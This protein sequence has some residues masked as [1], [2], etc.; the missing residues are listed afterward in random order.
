MELATALAVRGTLHTRGNWS[1][2][3]DRAASA[4]WLGILWVGVLAGFGVDFPRFLGENPPASPVIFVH[5]AVFTVWMLLLTAQVLL[6][7]GDR[8]GWHRTL[9]WFTAG[10]AL[11]VAVMGPWATVA[12]QLTNLHLPLAEPQFISINLA[13]L[14]GFLIL[15]A[16]GIVLRGNPAA[17]RRL[18]ILSTLSLA[19]DPGFSRFSEWLI[20]AEPASVL[21]WFF[22]SYYGNVLLV[23]LMLGWDW[24]RGRLMRSS[25]IAASALL[26]AEFAATL[27]YF[28]EPWK[29]LTAGW[30]Q[31]WAKFYA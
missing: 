27:L 6:V 11:L 1:A 31:M 2:R 18:M 24:W 28:W 15:L 9:G 16:W 19:G 26:A 10:W 12:F 5:A 7:L 17:H 23:V 8:V 20:P 30:V 25:V 29:A 22:W 14:G 4:V 3:D 13:D 21:P